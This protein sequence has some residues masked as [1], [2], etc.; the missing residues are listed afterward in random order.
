MATNSGEGGVE[1]DHLGLAGEGGEDLSSAEHVFEQME[2]GEPQRQ[3]LAPF[4]FLAPL[5]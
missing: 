3:V 5:S 1:S 4:S 2:S